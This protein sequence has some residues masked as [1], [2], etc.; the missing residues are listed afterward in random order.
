MKLITAAL[1]LLLSA[2]LSMAHTVQLEW[3]PNPPGET[4]TGYKIYE[5]TASDTEPPVITWKLIGQT[6]ANL[7]KASIEAPAGIHIYA[8]SAFNALGESERS[9]EVFASII[10]PPAGLK[11]IKVTVTATP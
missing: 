3:D 9:N 2:G 1:A 4:V 8:V 7:T 11:I 10:T 5:K 6:A